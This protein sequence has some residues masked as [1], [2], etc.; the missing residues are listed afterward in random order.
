VLRIVAAQEGM[1]AG[2][3]EYLG[4]QFHAARAE[5]QR[6]G[7]LNDQRAHMPPRGLGSAPIVTVTGIRRS[8]DPV[9]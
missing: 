4:R 3:P 5:P 7:D 9:A 1:Q 2:C 8:A 6:R